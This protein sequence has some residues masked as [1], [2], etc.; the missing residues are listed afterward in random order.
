MKNFILFSALVANVVNGAKIVTEKNLNPLFDRTKIYL[1]ENNHFQ[2]QTFRE[3]SKWDDVKNRLKT[4]DIQKIP[5]E[6]WKR[7]ITL[8]EQ[9]KCTV[10]EILHQVERI[11]NTE[12]D[13]AHKAG[14]F[15]WAGIFNFEKFS[16]YWGEK[17][18]R[19][20]GLTPEEYNAKEITTTV[21]TACGPFEYH[22]FFHNYTYT[23]TFGILT[24]TATG[25]TI[26]QSPG[27]DRNERDS[28]ANH[29][30]N[31]MECF[32]L[33]GR[34]HEGMCGEFSHVRIRLENTLKRMKQAGKLENQ[35]LIFWGHSQGGSVATVQAAYF[36]SKGY[37][38]A[39]LITHGS[40][41]V[42]TKEF[43]DYLENSGI[44]LKR[45]VALSR[46]GTPDLFCEF[47]IQDMA[48]VP[49]DKFYNKGYMHVGYPTPVQS[50]ISFIKNKHNFMPQHMSTHL[51]LSNFRNDPDLDFLLPDNYLEEDPT[52]KDMTHYRSKDLKHVI[53]TAIKHSVPVGGGIAVLLSGLAI[54][55]T[56]KLAKY[57]YHKFQNRTKTN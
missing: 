13:L 47:P 1:D 38:I 17:Q 52:R 57:L 14:E 4:E 55:G 20:K 56:K 42:G 44:H 53:G 7:K 3:I 33:P 18:I 2:Y 12:K 11:V 5:E 51:L 6:D 40:T 43:V 9:K 23:Q 26:V 46:E 48:L 28:D 25:L 35:K 41:R 54:H 8:A 39:A 27:T 32:D 22:M 24:H 50:D 49:K 21:E 37:K 10:T 19:P 31:T 34:V 16:P 36:Y 30:T 45:Y 29:K 15:G